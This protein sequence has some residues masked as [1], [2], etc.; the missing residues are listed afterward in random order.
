MTAKQLWIAVTF[1]CVVLITST[2]AAT[3]ST[4]YQDCK[5]RESYATGTDK[6]HNSNNVV[7]TAQ[8]NSLGILIDCEGT[9]ADTNGSA[10]TA[11]A[12]I[13]LTVV[14]GGLI[15]LGWLQ[16][17]TTRTQLRAQVF[18]QNF[19]QWWVPDTPS[20]GLYS[21]RFRPLWQNSGDTAAEEVLLVVTCE[22]R[23][24]ILPAKYDFENALAGQIPTP[25]LL[26]PKTTFGG[27]LAPAGFAI[28]PQD[29][30]DAQAG[31][32]FIYLYGWVRYLDVFPGTREHLT[33]FC[34]LILPTGDPFKF[35]PNDPKNTLSFTYVLHFEGNS[36]EEI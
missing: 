5:T 16:L 14:T 8:V 2:I 27:G 18:P 26:P 31:N 36:V 23:N 11:L 17:I 29:I 20:A 33:R 3:F 32:K 35:V 7:P 13:L 19:L 6:K 21:W 34:W 28:T 4:S 10:I 25:G 22:V 24:S 30:A 1:F 9:F 12:T 15:W